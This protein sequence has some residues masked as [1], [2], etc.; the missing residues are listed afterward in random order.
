MPGVYAAGDMVS[1]AHAVIM[2]AASGMKA[3]AMINHE[4]V[5]HAP[6]PNVQE[7]ATL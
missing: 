4:L 3:A 7:A 1:P 2:A 5:M 6:G